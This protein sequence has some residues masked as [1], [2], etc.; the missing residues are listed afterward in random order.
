MFSHRRMCRWFSLLLLCFPLFTNAAIPVKSIVIFGDSLSDNGNTTH[1]LKSLRQEE[2]PAF[3]V[4]PFKQFV[5]NKMIDFANDYY[6]PQMVLDKG[7]SIV[8][9]FF[10]YELAPYI[11]NLVSRVRLVPIL[12]GQPYWKSHFSNGRVWNEYLAKMFSIKK[13][14]NEAYTNKAFGGSWAATYDHQLTVWNL[15]RHPLGTIKTL[16]V[17]KLVPP[18]LG[19]TLQAYFLEHQRLDNEAVYFV[20]SGFNDYLNILVFEDNYNPAVMS[21]YVDNVLDNLAASVVKL[22]Q[23]G[24][25]HLVIMGIPELGELPRFVKTTDRDVMNAAANKHNER[26]E[27]RM[28]EWKK[29]YPKVDFLYINTAKSLTATLANPEK[30]GFTN[31]KD[32]CIDVKYPMFGAFANSPFANNF[33]LH[34]LQVIHYKDKH[35][36]AGDKNYE[37]CDNPD[38]YLFWDEVHP[39]TRAHRYL[40]LDVCN[41]MQ[42][43]GYEVNCELPDLS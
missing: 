17:G 31:I 11:A 3:L 33:V 37:M 43:H 12:P 38:S 4:A 34:Y 39:S 27:K 19:L 1:L 7:I 32:A 23:A 26:L 18:S 5:L 42:A 22:V 16:I 25:T 36:L 40:A 41:A 24:A 35:F 2:S 15:I 28:V 9:N 30:Y 20:Y 13:S 6:V 14:D 8:T 29:L 10:D 21:V